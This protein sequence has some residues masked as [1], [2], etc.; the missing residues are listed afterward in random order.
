[1][2]DRMFKLLFT[3]I[4]SQGGEDKF[5]IIINGL[6]SPVE[7]IVVAKR[8]AILLLILKEV[9]WRNIKEIVKVSL[10]SV[11]KCQMILLNNQE[12]K[13]TLAS[14]IA[15]DEMGIFFEEL[16]LA[17]FGP[18]TAYTNWKSAWKR[19]NELEQK[20]SQLL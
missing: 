17:F 4:G 18:G 19:K 7:K 14:I 1:V 11:S 10:S 16:F 3:V 2:M 12:M 5:S 13:T 6:F 15:K 9:D 8:I 20:K